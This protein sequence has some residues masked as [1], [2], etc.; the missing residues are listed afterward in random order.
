MVEARW[1]CLSV[2]KALP[3]QSNQHGNGMQ[4]R[5]LK[6]WNDEESSRF[7]QSVIVPNPVLIKTIIQGMWLMLAVA[8]VK[9]NGVVIKH[10]SQ[11]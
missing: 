8:P 6:R 11:R 9:T 7:I 10:L 1:T 4:K 2:I 3:W 5:F